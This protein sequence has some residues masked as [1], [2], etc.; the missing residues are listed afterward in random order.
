MWNN[1][2]LLNLAT[3][4]L[5]MV[6]LVLLGGGTVVWIAKRPL[7]RLKVVRIEAESGMLQHLNV[8][9][10]KSAALA[11]VRGNFFTVNLESVRLAFEGVPWVR[12]ARVRREWPNRLVVKV[13]EH[14]ALA[15]WDDGRL[16]NTYGELFTANPAEA[17]EDADLPEFSGPVG[18][19]HD[20]TQRY[21][22]FSNWFSRL[23]LKP[24]QVTLSPRYA[25]TVRLD[26]GTEEE[27]TVELGRERDGSTLME[28]VS[29]MVTVYPIVTTK[30]PK[31]TLVDLRYPNGFALRAQGLKL[32]SEAGLKGPAPSVRHG[33]HGLQKRT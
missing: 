22:D 26:N 16:V 9:S 7:F 8:A 25:W 18:S 32:A 4:V 2:R 23:N 28:R 20:V 1:L 10:V 30:W 6:A 21:R 11:E 14:Q 31:L 19:E 17:E 27:L 5:F 29:R 15:T 24:D 12:H 3:T 13:E 33:S